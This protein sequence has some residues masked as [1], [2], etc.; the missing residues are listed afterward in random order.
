VH[1]QPGAIT[2]RNATPDGI[3][4][5]TVSVP[6]V[7]VPPVLVTRTRK[8]RG[9]LLMNGVWLTAMAR[10]PPVEVASR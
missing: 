7:D 4:S 6:D 1:D 9:R 2:P 5:V 10:S 8:A 3:W